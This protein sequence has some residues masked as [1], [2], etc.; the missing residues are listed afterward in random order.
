SPLGWAR[1]RIVEAVLLCA[2]LVAASLVVFA[3]WLGLEGYPLHYTVFPF[4]IWAAL[5]LGQRGTATVTFI[6]SS[7]A[8]GSAVNG[9]GPFAMESPEASLVMLQLFMAIVAV[10]GL[11]L[12]AAITERDLAESRRREDFAQLQLSEEGLRLALD[13]GRMGVWDW[14][15]AS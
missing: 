13:A 14:D 6:A 11:L 2:T 4:L 9:T 5:R 8:S 3:G 15:I 7:L 10:A 1:R 12:G